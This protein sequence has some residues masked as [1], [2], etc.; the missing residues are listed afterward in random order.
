MK[1][2]R[3]PK[4]EQQKAALESLGLDPDE[5]DS[6]DN[7]RRC[8]W[9]PS[10]VKTIKFE[11][12][13]SEFH[14]MNKMRPLTIEC[15]PVAVQTLLDFVRSKLKPDHAEPPLDE[16]TDGA[17]HAAKDVCPPVQGKVLWHPGS[18]SWNV[19]FKNQ[20]KRQIV[21]VIELEEGPI[22]EMRQQ[23]YKRAVS[24]WNDNDR[25]TRPRITTN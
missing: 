25:S 4:G 18:K 10:R 19:H 21:E 6:D 20:L 15:T 16:N 7:D 3:M 17:F 22:K 23:A 13:G 24:F 12:Q 1:A 11:W 8:G 14:A 9:K 2:A 5:L